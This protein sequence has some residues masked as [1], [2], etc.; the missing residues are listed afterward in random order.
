MAVAA[1]GV[2]RSGSQTFREGR[3]WGLGRVGDCMPC[4]TLPATTAGTSVRVLHQ[5][6]NRLLRGH[7]FWPQCGSSPHRV[8]M[9][10]GLLSTL[11]QVIVQTPQRSRTDSHYASQ[12]VVNR[13]AKVRGPNRLSQSS[14]LAH[15]CLDD[16]GHL[17]GNGFCAN[18]LFIVRPFRVF[19]HN[20]KSIYKL[21]CQSA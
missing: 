4:F 12:P 2:Q 17:Y 1:C 3:S 9:A 7:L 14:D 16:R 11:S 19:F 15:E 8:F 18:F 20:K 21:L 5:R 10:L 13:F 6:R